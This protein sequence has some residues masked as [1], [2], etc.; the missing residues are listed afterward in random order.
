MLGMSNHAYASFWCRDFS[1]G[2]M[3]ERFGHFLE[4]VPFSASHRGFTQFLIR[5]VGPAEA[6]VIEH[7]LRSVPLSAA[8][9]IELAQEHLHADCVYETR[10]HWDLWTYGPTTGRW[11][12]RAQPLDIYCHGEDYDDRVWQEAGHLQADIGFEHLFT[13]HAGL[14][15][16]REP[17]VPVP[18]HPAER[19]FIEAM[20]RPEN[21]REYHEK[22]R[23]NIRLLLHWTT[24]I[25]AAVPIERSQLWSEG[26]EN[27]E[28]RMEEI[29]AV[30]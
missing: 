7:D 22:T 13:G 8:E 6:P 18:Q 11:E 5:A 25:E 10:A 9:I 28:A 20:I 12:M 16:V 26:E 30:R 3:L 2:T 19:A 29:L 14:L 27:F 21:L 15:G 24:K 1:E 23:E 4:T 17:R